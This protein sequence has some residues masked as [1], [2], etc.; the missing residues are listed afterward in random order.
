VQQEV[1]IEEC[2]TGGGEMG[3]L[4]RTHDG[5]AFLAEGGEMGERIRAFDWS[6]TALG[7]TES[8]S[9]ALR[10]VVRLMLANRL[11]MLLWWGPHYISIYNDPYRPVL[12]NKHPWGLGLPVRE[13][14]QEVWHVLKPLI[15]TPFHGGPATW[16]EDILLFLNRYGFN[17]ET[18]WLIA[19]SPVPDESV[20][21]GIGGVLA[22]VHETT[23]KVLSERR[24]T[25]LHDL[26]SRPAEAKTAEAACIIAAKML[27][28][29]GEDIPFALLYLTDADGRH[30]RLAATAGVVAGQEIGQQFV[31]LDVEG[32]AWPLTE[33]KRT[34][35][36]QVVAQLGA[37]FS[38]VPPGPWPDPPTTAVVVPI[39]SG[40]PH[41][42]AGF[43]VAGVSSRL[44]LDDAYL[45][46]LGLVTTQIAT[47]VANARAY[48]E[49]KRRA[50]S[51]AELDRAKT[52]FFS[53]VSH[54]FR[55]PLTLML[56]PVEDALAETDGALRP[57]QRERLEMVQ[58]NGLR[59]QK[60]VNTLLD[61]SRIE[62]G[63]VQASY[64]PTDLATFTAELASNFRSACDKAGLVLHVD[65]PPLPQPVY[66]DREMWEKIVLNLLSNAFKFTLK[67]RIEVSLR[68]VNGHADLT[69]RDTGMG[70]PV[71]EMP[72][73]FE[74]FH[75]VEGSRGRTQEGS[76]IGLALVRELAKLHGGDVWAE[77]E[78]GKGSM[79]TVSLPL[80]RAHL[81]ADRISAARTLA[82]TALGAAPYIEE[83]L[84]WLPGSS[85]AHRGRSVLPDGPTGDIRAP[86]DER[87]K[88]FWILL[89]DDNADMRDY[90]RRLLAPQYDVTTVADGQAALVA[91]D[92]AVPDLILS[93]VMMPGLDGFGLLRQLRADPR[94]REV[95]VI[96]LSARAGEESR[97]EG[98]E[99]GADDYLIKPFSARELLARVQA[100]LELA[101][102]RRESQEALRQSEEHLRAVV[103]TTPACIKVVAAD[104]TL[105]DM[106]SA[107]LE[108]VDADVSESVK[109][110][111]VYNLISEEYREAFRAFN[112]R[113]CRGE[114]G[115]LEFD[116]VGLRGTR[117]RMETH[118][119]PL[120]WPGGG[121]VQLAITHDITERKRAED[122]LKQSEERLRLLWE[123]ATVLLTTDDPDAMLRSLFAKIGPHFA[124]DT[125][126]NFLL[127][128]TGD[129]LRLG[130]CA[131]IPEEEAH[132]ITRLEFGQA[133]CGT[134]ALRRQ[135]IVATHIQ[136]SDEPMVQ[137]VKGYGVRAYACN[138][139]L[140]E[141]RLLGTL[142]F[143]SHSRD[144]FDADDLEFLRTI[145]QYVT[146]AY[147]RLRLVRQ[148]Q[149][150]DRRKDE[151]LATLAH[152]LRNPLAPIR[153][154]LQLLRLAGGNPATLNQARPMME[155]QVQQMV[156]LV[157]DLLDVSRINRNKLELRK[158]WVELAGVVRSAVET[159]RPLIEAAA[160]ELTV[161]L[162]REPVLL[163]ADPVRLAQAFS[164]LLNNAAKYSERGG[165]IWLTA[166]HLGSEIMVRVR[167]TG[168]G[169][170]ADKLPHIFEMFVQVDRSLE[171]SQ[172]G[173]GIGLTL[174][175]RLVQMHGGSVEARSDGPGKGSEFVVRLP[176]VSVPKPQDSQGSGEAA[177]QQVRHRILVV[178][179]NRDSADS[180]AMM[181]KL[182]GH[183]VATAHDGLQ[184]VE[185]VGAFQPNVALLDLGMPKLNGYDAA[186]RIRDKW[187]KNDLVLIAL[188][189]W[190]QEEDRRRTREAGFN[191]HLVKPVDLDALQK[192]IAE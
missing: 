36:R 124:L 171:R 151:F 143:A 119:V 131:G 106:N 142:S 161:S 24:M 3:R 60:L 39:G 190:G 86:T 95:P 10:T 27:E 29:H 130:S 35:Q 80:G 33:A 2:L 98:M 56:G 58:R 76:G 135:P 114:K 9:P 66:V 139:L 7:P 16:D 100:R 22:T 96:L 37:R 81:P 68:R 64:E 147:E 44:Q 168:I 148:L 181:L 101:K 109:G 120:R 53:N 89:A 13:C 41:E 187:G 134:V 158:E 14:W 63:R 178:D 28:A 152:E 94:T 144:E 189:G 97:V 73:L 182:L 15:D 5:L 150:Q 156:R 38:S 40:K 137:L 136:Q 75:R 162:P 18:H 111:S 69:V 4:L 61:F 129:G 102:L 146:V 192:L 85:E 107:G 180:L 132:K 78:F 175:Q 185:M 169:V 141:G 46:F 110:Q 88:R 183:E 179:D 176:V 11:P 32:G 42:P 128:E 77:S 45:G 154:G 186:R 91:A 117:R 1:E 108:M 159:S 25:A 26:G 92:K 23:E 34:M 6:K 165:H 164:N 84:R 12:G 99:A 55:T 30:A 90:V 67:G 19:Y 8:W 43:L 115:S 51:L 133:V 104:G 138:P 191:H 163:D 173:L 170:P 122:A 123:A 184:A 82:S 79:F 21:S 48:E 172:G 87:G 50:E 31:D 174:V 49:E 93:D 177:G 65:C 72:K 54:E 70:I 145:S 121:L 116:M 71:E 153:N 57:S 20:P 62:A 113:V 74:R 149:E 160:H 112:E 167:D 188:T 155:R 52:A 83:A 127:N 157:D 140:V 103:E 126:F 17:E 125:Y 59:L 47:A 166:E 118:A 105:L